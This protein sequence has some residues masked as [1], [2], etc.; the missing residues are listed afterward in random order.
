MLEKKI[1]INY[2]VIILEPKIAGNIGAI[3]RICNNFNVN[4]LVLVSP[5][6]D[7]LSDEA[8]ARAKHSGNY[9]TSAKVLSSI[10]EIRGEY[11]FLIG[12][13]A[14]AG[15]SYNVLRQPIFPWHLSKN[16]ILNE[17]NFGIVFGREDKGLTN[18]ELRMCDFLVSIPVP[19]KHKV[20]NISH[21]VGIMVYEI[22]KAPLELELQ[23]AEKQTSTYKEREVLFEKFT[24]ITD[25]LPYEE[26][27]KPILQHTFRNIVN[28]SFTNKEEIHALIG[29]FRTIFNQLSTQE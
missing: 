15:S 20:L 23:I 29:I 22:W 8:K 6:V 25:V 5:Q 21:A 18:E 26:Y 28:R 4:K 2:D 27:R 11:D 13:S 10:D 14:K 19:G 9:L 17:G 7:H 24:Q 1:E 16:I 12:T 3:A